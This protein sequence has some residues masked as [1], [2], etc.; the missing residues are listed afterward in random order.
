[1]KSKCAIIAGITGQDG[2]YL[3]ELLLEKG[4]RIVGLTRDV[5]A[6]LPDHIKHL[7]GKIK[8]QYCSYTEGSVFESVRE[9]KPDEIYNLTAQSY[10]SKSWD[11][12]P[13]TIQ[14]N[15]I[16]PIYFLQAIVKLNCKIKFFQASS[17]EIFASQPGEILTENSP[18]QATNPYGAS[19]AFAHQMV[20]MFRRYHNVYAVNGILFNHESP[21]RKFDFI[22][23]KIVQAAVAIKNGRRK[24]LVLGNTS[25]ARD[26]GYAPDY[27]EAVY[28]MMNLDTPTD[29]IISTG[30]LH[31]VE[32]MVSEVFKKL[33]LDKKQFVKTDPN[34]FRPHEIPSVVGS[35]Q[36]INELTG[37]KPKVSFEQM[38]HL[39]VDQE[40]LRQQEL[41]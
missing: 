3:A 34:L 5:S 8:L 40:L 30:I 29:L 38:I 24:E 18:M 23:Q 21:R 19:K 22:S 17:S 36:K 13:E 9:N 6:H 32:D 20:S 26:W 39:M 1:M 2:S 28:L 16:L 37:W 27:M 7:E 33:N 10:V 14:N 12:I 35:N 41:S 15:S 25:V 11:M 31:S 4:Y